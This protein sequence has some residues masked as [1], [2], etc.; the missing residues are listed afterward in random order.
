MEV[1]T[2]PDVFDRSTRPLCAMLKVAEPR[3]RCTTLRNG[4]SA[5]VPPFT[6][7]LRV[8]FLTT[9]RC[10]RTMKR[11][12][13]MTTH[14]RH[15]MQPCQT[16]LLVRILLLV[17]DASHRSLSLLPHLLH[18]ATEQAPGITATQV[19]NATTSTRASVREPKGVGSRS[20]HAVGKETLHPHLQFMVHAGIAVASVSANLAAHLRT[21]SLRTPQ[22]A[23]S[24]VLPITITDP[25]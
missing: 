17:A 2:S 18:P 7:P 14:L 3:K 11:P 24:S 19:R 1:V 21:Y 12:S 13:N 25:L 4:Y 22:Q 20:G 15:Q 9:W 6:A 23:P 10:T 8:S 16:C 5:V